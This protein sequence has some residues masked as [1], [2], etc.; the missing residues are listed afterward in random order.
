MKKGFYCVF[1]LLLTICLLA[2]SIPA[3]VSAEA[4]DIGSGNWVT[5]GS[6][7]PFTT[8]NID[9]AAKNAP[10]YLQQLS[11]GIVISAPA[12]I[13][14]PFRGGQFHWEPRIMK[15]SNNNWISSTSSKEYIYS[16]EAVEYACTKAAV[17]GTYALFGYYDGPAESIE[18]MRECKFTF[19][20]QYIDFGDVN[21]DPPGTMHFAIRVMYFDEETYG[22]AHYIISN[23][24]GSSISADQLTGDMV[25]AGPAYQSGAFFYTPT[26]T[27]PSFNMRVIFPS[28]CYKD[29][30]FDA[31]ITPE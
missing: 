29:L 22:T 28:G 24:T 25:P 27:K 8:V 7:T 12:K 18:K 20:G 4:G 17:A 5:P 9:K 13:C 10:S 1:A 16:D 30:F 23:V 26:T 2:V 3:S 31:N 15:L 21:D 6:S 11:E 14:Y 19:S